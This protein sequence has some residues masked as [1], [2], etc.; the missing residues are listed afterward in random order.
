MSR[1][2]A[3]IVKKAD[4][5]GCEACEIACKQEHNL[6]VGPRWIR[7]TTDSPKL[8]D[9]KLQLRYSVSHC[10]HCTEPGCLTSCPQNAITKRE[11]GIVLIDADLCTGCRACVDGC[12]IG[13]MQFD[14][15]KGLAEKCDL[16]VARHDRG[17]NPVCVN[18]CPN[19]CIYYG[20]TSDIFN[21]ADKP[22]LLATYKK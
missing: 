15:N 21:K 1:E 9:G 4:C 6:P 11:D 8:I 13:V 5:I 17:L 19:K 2:Y 20:Y 7:V 10:L 14:D 16:C 3:L 12:P 18:A 22:A